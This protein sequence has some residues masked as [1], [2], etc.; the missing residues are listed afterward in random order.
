M[1]KPGQPQG[2]V[3][4]STSIPAPVG[5]WNARDSLA[6]MAITDAVSMENYFPS[7]TT[8]TLRDGYSS[9]AVGLLSQVET[10]M[11]YNGGATE[12]LIAIT[13][14]GNIYNITSA[15]SAFNYLNLPGADADYASTP[16]STNLDITGDLEI[17]A[18]VDPD[19]WTPGTAQVI[20]C[21]WLETGNQRSYMLTIENDGTLGLYISTSGAA[22]TV[23]EMFSPDTMA[24]LFTTPV[25]V[26]ASVD[27]SATSNSTTCAFSYSATSADYVSLGTATRTMNYLDLPGAI[28]DYASTPDS[29]ALDITGDI[30][31]R[32][33]IAPDDWTIAAGTNVVMGKWNATANQR[34]FLFLVVNSGKLYF[35]WS[36]DGTATAG[37]L[38]S[39]SS[40]E[41]VSFTD[42]TA[43]WVRVTLD[44]DNGL[45]ATVVN[46]YTSDDGT[47][48][49]QLG[50]TITGSD[51]P[52]NI[53]S[54]TAVLKLG[55]SEVDAGS[56]FYL[57]GQIYKAQVYNGIGGTLAAEFTGA[58]A[59]LSAATVTSSATGE[60]YTLAGSA[61]IINTG[62]QTNYTSSSASTI[63]SS[64]AP[65]WI[66]AYQTASADF[67]SFDGKIYLVK[68]YSGIAGTLKASFV[69]ND[70]TV[71]MTSF[72]STLTGETYTINGAATIA[73]DN[74]LEVEGLTNGR[75]QHVN[76]TNSGGTSY[77]VMANGADSV[78]NY[79]GTTWT[80]P[81]ITGVTSSTLNNVN[82][83][84]SRLWFTQ[85]ST[86]K[87]WYLP[88]QAISGAAAALDLS[89]Y[90]PHGGTLMAMGT[91]TVDAGYGVDDLAVFVTNQG[92]VLVY[93]GTDPSSSVTWALVG[94]WWIGAPIGRR[95][96]VKYQGD[97]LIICEDG[98]F[99]L[100]SALQS[101]RVNPKVALTDKIQQEMNTSVNLYRNNFGWQVIPYD[102]KNMIF[103]NV[104]K[105]EGSQQEQYIMNTITGAWCKFTGWEANCWEIYNDGLYFGGDGIV[106]QAWNTNADAGTAIAGTVQQAFN[107]Y[108]TPGQVKRFTMMRPILRTN[109]SPSIQ[110][111]IN[112]DFNLAAPASN[113]AT[114]TITGARWD[115]A[116]WDTDV[117][118]DTLA[119]S[120][121][122]QGATGI[123]Y[124]GGVRLDSS[125][126]GLQLEWVA[127]DVVMEP[128]AIL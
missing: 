66:G 84:K 122:W 92:D 12:K 31:L 64:T 87:A 80:T 2:R 38:I 30:D 29:A 50:S 24:T 41:A 48:W 106:A 78:R 82:I 117:W 5:G 102:G 91:W 104:P 101:S 44:V 46:F 111:A 72:A 20:A 120:K 59:L 51:L 34:S 76:F 16:D 81:S 103:L 47:T 94:Q 14:N 60:V 21:K 10:L 56:E 121:N 88:T 67:D 99:Q 110:G 90:C 105:Q 53:F 33:L 107:Y 86:L 6:D 35:S 22:G 43:H 52:S 126:N 68:V 61:S 93:R 75:W 1:R 32:A 36:K 58:D 23:F 115:S 125:T 113:L 7:T 108:K 28:T 127:T 55:E 116:V 77:L 37:Q 15:A 119:V 100:S 112:T 123:G 26:K 63:Y 62:S 109:G 85:N 4:T 27:I 45:N 83:H 18:Y 3:S 25:Y 97:M 65:W 98:L 42:G 74:G 8:V 128:G 96:F 9:T 39:V 57:A 11:A 114:V 71:G 95:C 54:S 19:D 79:D 118:Q 49:T 69:P 40:T 89:A 17:I 73:N 124:S 70:T 13:A